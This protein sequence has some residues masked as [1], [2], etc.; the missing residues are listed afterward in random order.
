MATSRDVLERRHRIFRPSL[1]RGEAP[2]LGL[3]LLETHADVREM[4]QQ[5]SRCLERVVAGSLRY[6]NSKSRLD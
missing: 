6:D 5:Q 3:A 4:R 2:K 1:G